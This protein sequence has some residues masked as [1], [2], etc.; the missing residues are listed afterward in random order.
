MNPEE[1]KATVREFILNEFVP[2]ESPDSLSD[3]IFAS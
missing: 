1:I 3:A 2:G